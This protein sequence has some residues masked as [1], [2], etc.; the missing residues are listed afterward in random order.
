MPWLVVINALTTCQVFYTNAEVSAGRFSFLRWFIP[1]H[2]LYVAAVQ[3]VIVRCGE[4][5]MLDL[6][7]C[8]G[9]I[10]LFRFIFAVFG[11]TVKLNESG[12][13]A[14]LRS[15]DCDII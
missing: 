14:V 13:N 9:G 2:L 8:F 6:M 15:G 7:I 11:V 12:R 1:L 3:L 5:S 10:S 4:V